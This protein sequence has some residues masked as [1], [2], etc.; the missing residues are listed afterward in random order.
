MK[1]IIS[2]FTAAVIGGLTVILVSNKFLDTQ[3]QKIVERIVQQPS[4]STKFTNSATSGTATDFT[5]AAEKTIN[6]VVHVKTEYPSNG[7][8]AYFDPFD[9]FFGQG[10]G[11]QQQ[12]PAM[13]SGSGV[14]ISAD[15]YI[16]T[17]N[18]VVADADKV[19]ITLNNNKTYVAELIGTDPTTDIALLK[20][21]GADFPYVPYGNSDNVKI[22]EWV[23]AVG[24]PFNL[25][26]TVTAVS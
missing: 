2:L 9:F 23:L 8:P 22:G 5:F 18:H 25:T 7:N 26:S 4:S 10:G 20:I 11:Y 19:S 21:S 6:S 14:I 15:G 12:M 13:A 3:P 16:V 17:N 24:N 1:K